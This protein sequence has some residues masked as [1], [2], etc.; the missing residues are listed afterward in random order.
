MKKFFMLTPIVG[1]VTLGLGFWGG[2]VYQKGKALTFVG[3]GGQN[4]PANVQQQLRSATTPQQRQQILRQSGL[5]GGAGGF[6]GRGGLSG[7][8]VSKDASSMTIKTSDGSTHVVYYTNATTVNKTMA[9]SL[10]DVTTGETIS[11]TGSRNSDGSTSATAIQIRPA[12]T[13]PASSASN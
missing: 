2:V 11:V 12:P 4:L 9:G 6:G 10:S 8:V 7:D 3:R 1:L 5:S 13:T